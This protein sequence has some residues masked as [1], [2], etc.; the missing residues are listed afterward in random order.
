MNDNK[1]GHTMK[2][3]QEWMFQL[4]EIEVKYKTAEA[5]LREIE[6]QQ[7]AILNNIPD[8]AWLKD[9]ES[10]FI[11]VNEAF[12]KS[13]GFKPEDL[14]GK[15]DLDLWPR[16]LAEKYRA[17]D[18]E[19]I[20]SQKRKRVEERFA[21][22][23]GKVSW[24]ETI[25]TPVFN[26]RGQVIGTT[27][28]ARD[29]TERKQIEE[30][31]R[32]A[33]AELEIRVKVRTAELSRANEDLHREI[34]HSKH[35]EEEL[36]ENE[37]F[38]SSVFSSIQDGICVLDTE[39]NIIRVNHAMEKWYK[40]AMPLVGKKCYQ[41]YHK[42]K[43]PCKICPVAKT[44]QTNEAAHDV[45]PRIGDN[46]RITGWLELFSFPLMDQ[47]TGQLKGV[48]EYVHDITALKRAEAKEKKG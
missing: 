11:C 10:R 44:L 7:R 5:A 18:K 36:V 21:G 37:R 45:I 12:G 43:E 9:K 31:Q 26:D 38:L 3:L 15:T 4:E 13:C 14:V 40:H 30:R 1:N 41:A 20:A 35:I 17:D 33:R 34:L 42:K 39:M 32:E 22:K 24:L 16:D 8:I 27:G 25:K 46:G 6:F 28:I 48:I 19:V 2:S 47:A 23:E 29:I